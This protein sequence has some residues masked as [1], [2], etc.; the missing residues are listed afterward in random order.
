MNR[1]VLCKG[2]IAEAPVP[3]RL[4]ILWK[5]NVGD[6]ASIFLE[7]L[8]DCRR[9]HIL[10]D[11][12]HENTLRRDQHLA[13]PNRCTLYSAWRFWCI[14]SVI[15]GTERRPSPLIPSF[16]PV[17]CT[18]DRQ[19]DT[20]YLMPTLSKTSIKVLFCFECDVRYPSTLVCIRP[21]TSDSWQVNVGHNSKFFEVLAKSVI[22]D[23]ISD[24]SNKDTI[25][26]GPVIRGCPPPPARERWSS[27]IRIIIG[28]G[29]LK[30]RSSESRGL[31]SPDFVLWFWI[32]SL[33]FN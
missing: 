5:I 33:G 7:V 24:F 28:H 26:W 27:N 18:T 32:C 14:A 16:K 2:N 15:R 13:T 9:R 30:S 25:S 17:I 23:C 6:F 22:R 29:W 10:R 11:S 12:S 1:D 31:I 21:T 19:L 20:I 3:S 4:G 8:A